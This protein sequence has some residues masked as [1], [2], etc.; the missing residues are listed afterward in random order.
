MG[1]AVKKATAH[2]HDWR[3]SWFGYHVQEVCAC[4]AYRTTTYAGCEPWEVTEAPNP[5]GGET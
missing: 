4:G 3:P 1:E 2:S 5:S